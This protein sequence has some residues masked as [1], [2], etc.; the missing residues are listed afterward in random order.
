MPETDTINY[1]A[2]A[3]GGFRASLLLRLGAL[4]MAAGAL[5]NLGTQLLAGPGTPS[6]GLTIIA[7]LLFILGLWLLAAGFIWL[8]ASPFFSRFGF[9]AGAFHAIQ[10]IQLL[11]V[12]FTFTPAILPPISLIIGRLVSLLFFVWID[13]EW[14]S[15]RT[16][17]LLAGAVGLELLK[18]SLRGLSYMPD[19]GLPLE[20]LLDTVLL[21][22]L[23]AALIQLGCSVRHAENDWAQMVYGLNH[24]DFSDFNN[25]EHDWNKPRTHGKK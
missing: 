2:A 19:L 9:V 23:A 21:L 1:W 16:I 13:R 20:P 6:T 24:S 18:I 3:G 15:V 25:P 17:R 10:G 14:M 4:V 5:A 11:L 22:L 8:G 7:W 12:L